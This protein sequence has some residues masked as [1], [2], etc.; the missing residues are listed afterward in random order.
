[1]NSNNSQFISHAI[2]STGSGHYKFIIDGEY[3]HKMKDGAYITPKYA[4]TMDSVYA[5]GFRATNGSL[6]Y[7]DFCIY[8]I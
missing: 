3:I 8:Q 4:K 5:I 1:M 7:K 2:E 6:T